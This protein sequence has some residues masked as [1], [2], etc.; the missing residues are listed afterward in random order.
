MSEVNNKQLFISHS[1]ADNDIADQIYRF[2]ESK[3]IVCWMDKYDIVPGVPY[4][5][6]IMEGLEECPAFVVLLSSNS[7]ESDDVLNEIDQAHAY[8]KLLIPVFL[9]SDLKLPQDFSYYLKRRQWIYLNDSLENCIDEICEALSSNLGLK[10]DDSESRDNVVANGSG[11]C[12]LLKIKPNEDCMV[13][14]DGDDMGI[15]EHEKT[16]KF[17]L[18][19]GE[20]EVICRC[21]K[22]NEEIELDGIVISNK[23]LLRKPEFKKECVKEEIPSIVGKVKDIEKT[24]TSLS[25]LWL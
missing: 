5:R 10:F 13:L 19:P 8:K 25:K 22:T 2:F 3:R 23:D 18:R 21:I 6:A 11:Q 20:Y 4:A 16:T 7:I 1:S 9:E 17:E 14:V 12:Y 15:A 24:I